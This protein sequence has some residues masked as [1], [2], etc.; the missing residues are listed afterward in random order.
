MKDA[1]GASWT[2]G[3]AAGRSIPIGMFHIARPDADD[4]ES[5][6]AALAGGRNLILTPGVYHLDKALEVA[7]PG[8]V[9]LGLGMATLVADNGTAA[10]RIADVDGVSVAGLLID[11]GAAESPVLLQ[12]GEPGSAADHSADPTSLHDIFIRVGGPR[13]GMAQVAVQVNSNDVIGDHFW[14]WRADHGAG[15]GWAGNK[16]RNGLVVEGDRVTFYGLFVE[17][18][19]E[20]QTIWNGEN[21]RT[22]FYQSE[23]PYDPPS[24]EQWQHDGVKGW[25]S[26]KVGPSV[27]A[28]EAWGLGVYCAF[29]AGPIQSDHAVEAPLAP[30]VQ[31]RHIVAVWLNGVDGSGIN[32]V[33]NATGG[34]VTK[35]KT[36]STVD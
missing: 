29:R 34:A 32:N 22:Y 30:G 11:A 16:A 19:Q 4:A 17:H 6:N 9:V 3:P 18:F 5:L 2:K 31:V 26:Y 10:L 33:L 35:Q 36:R 28:H 25:A 24:R 12:V 15:V 21:G 8:T 23:M 7:R 14:I 13:P 1:S 20:Y 27:K